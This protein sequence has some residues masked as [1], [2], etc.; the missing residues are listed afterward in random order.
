M[1]K[2]S[3]KVIYKATADVTGVAFAEQLGGDVLKNLSVVKVNGVLQ[4]ATDYIN[5]GDSVE[6]LSPSDEDALKALRLTCTQLLAHAVKSLFPTCKLGVCGIKKDEFFYDID[7]VTPIS[8]EDLPEIEK[9]MKRIIKAGFCVEKTLLG[10]AE[11][12]EKMSEY[13]E[14]YKIR[15]LE[16]FPAK[17]KVK[18]YKIGGFSDLCSGPLV[19]AIKSIKAF[20]LN[21]I[22]G[23]YWKNNNKNK[24][25]TRI[26]GTAFFKRKN[27]NEYI[28]TKREAS[29]KNYAKICKKLGYYYSDDKIGKGLPQ[30]L[31]KGYKVLNILQRFVEDEEEKRGY[32]F[33]K[34]PCISKAELFEI[35]GQL[36]HYKDKMYIINSFDSDKEDYVLRPSACPFHYR[37]FAS[38][39]KSYKDLPVRYSETATVFRKE[40]SGETKELIRLRQFTV[41]DGHTFMSENQIEDEFEKSLDLTQY[42]LRAIGLEKGVYYVLETTDAEKGK[43]RSLIEK[44]ENAVKKTFENKGIGYIKNSLQLNSDGVKVKIFNR[45]YYGKEEELL[46]FSFDFQA[47]KNFGLSYIDEK[48]K[49]K[50]PIVLHRSSIGC[51]EKT[52]ATLIERYS[53]KLPLWL[54]PEQV[55]ILSVSEKYCESVKELRSELVKNKIR[56]TFDVRNEK[57]GKKI[58]DA[59][60]EKVPYVLLVGDK[61]ENGFLSVRNAVGNVFKMTKEQF[62]QKISEEIV[63][64]K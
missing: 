43:S 16:S 44:C 63:K 53:G 10:K 20:Q 41:S 32:T 59:V 50:N 4:D 12:I 24:M 3:E 47:G 23:A 38:S 56:A 1:E 54:A 52:L 57:T 55:R 42:V 27:L 22:A 60:L 46:S 49:K 15:L 2:Q 51:Y 25:L 7:F 14:L 17:E 21:S 34:T 28:K 48:G 26:Y 40:A 61:E 11:A 19:Y 5:K 9:E 36:G 31:E 8:E 45:S 29:E 6:F 58:R 35:S 30:F 33:I 13:S 62:I 37:V 64:N 39:L 18:L